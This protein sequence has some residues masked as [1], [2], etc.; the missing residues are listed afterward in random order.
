MVKSN[1]SKVI[2]HLFHFYHRADLR[3]WDYTPQN[4]KK[5]YGVYHI[6]CVNDW[7]KLVKDQISA[8][9]DSGLY[10]ITCTLFV[11]C[12]I[13]NEEETSI[14][15][16]IIGREKC[17]IISKEYKASRCEFPALEFMHEKS[18]T[19]DFFVYYFHTK[20]VSL[21][22][23]DIYQDDDVQKLREYSTAWRKMMEYFVFYKHNVA[24]NV[25]NNY[26]VFGTCYK[27]YRKCKFFAGNF[28]WSKS[29]YIKTLPKF[30]PEQY[31]NRFE[32]EY[33]ILKNTRNHFS[34]FDTDAILYKIKIYSGIYMS[35]R[36]ISEILHFVVDYYYYWIKLILNWLT[37]RICGIVNVLKYKY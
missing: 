20:G 6:D 35:R 37:N 22:Y 33:W 15:C 18:Q 30:R 24:I 28:W 16:D 3:K 19:E 21:Q 8:L 25:L 27:E 2:N 5:I 1:Y 14:I 4:H 12:I 9:K 23:G 17:I 32:A 26:D 13:S 10:D 29:S 7:K 34:A 11:S 31:I 36:N